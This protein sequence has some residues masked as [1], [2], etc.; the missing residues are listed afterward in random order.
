MSV[1]QHLI[2][3]ASPESQPVRT[4]ECSCG[5]SVFGDDSR[6]RAHQVVMNEL[7]AQWLDHV[8]QGGQ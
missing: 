8:E 3:Y 6:S 1:D 2:V 5:W 7:L 4:V